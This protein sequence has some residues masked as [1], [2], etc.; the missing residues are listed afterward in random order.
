MRRD[1]INAIQTAREWL[2][3]KPV[4]LDTETTGLDG[5][6]QVCDIAIIDHNG[7]VLLDTLI[8]PTRPI[9]AAATRVHGISNSDVA[10]APT[11]ANIAPNLHQ[12]IDNKLIVI[13]NAQFDIQMLTQSARAHGI[14]ESPVAD[15]A[16]AMNLYAA[17]WGAW[18]NYH[19]SYTWQK[20]SDAARQCG[21]QLPA[22]L[23]RARADAELT[24]QIIQFMADDK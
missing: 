11:F 5:R 4:Y 3:M 2:Q 14:K 18:S 16:C 17:Y 15:W 10:D 9:P 20:L 7:D 8:K 19:Q 23:H 13:Y 21:I 24:R 12:L 6:A 1:K 22:T